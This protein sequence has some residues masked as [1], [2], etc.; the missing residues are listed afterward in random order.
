MLTVTLESPINPIEEAK[1][2]LGA[3]GI[4]LKMKEN[5]IQI[6]G[7]LEKDFIQNISALNIAKITNERPTIKKDNFEIK[8]N[9]RV[10]H[11]KANFQVDETATTHQRIKK[12][13]LWEVDF[14]QPVGNEF[15]YKHPAIVIEQSDTNGCFRV[16]PC[17]T[18]AK[19]GK[20][21][22]LRFNNEVLKV[23]TP[24][25]LE[26]ARNKISNV[27]FDLEIP[28][29][30]MRFMR[31]LGTL[32]E[33]VYNEILDMRG[34]ADERIKREITLESL[35]LTEK[36]VEI[37]KITDRTTEILRIANNESY[38]Y[39]QRVKGILNVFG[40][41]VQL[42]GDVDYLVKLVKNTRYKTPYINIHQEVELLTRNTLEHPKTINNK[43]TELVNKKFRALHPC[44]L[45][46]VTLVN[47]MAS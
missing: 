26:E 23:S 2:W 14:G 45:E 21:Y 13:E 34:R 24:E 15:G 41:Y 8:E 35:N 40:F 30:R 27:L 3:P 22:Q 20:T 16:L 6:E 42:G 39:E 1:K 19:S 10:T 7:N 43:L 47:K 18:K 5:T 46:F 12:A 38:S 17:S 11:I 33:S 31:Y 44:L 9:G 32:D 25:F 36:Q 28:V 37:L 29:D 4:S